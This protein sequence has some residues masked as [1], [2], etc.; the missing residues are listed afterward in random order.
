MATE[1]AITMAV[2]LAITVGLVIMVDPAIA[3]TARMETIMVADIPAEAGRME[4]VVVLED[5]AAAITVA[6]TDN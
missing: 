4:V 6:V 2:D 3:G 1:E 5:M